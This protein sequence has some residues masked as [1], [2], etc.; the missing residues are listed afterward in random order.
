M[1]NR[2]DSYLDHWRGIFHVLMLADHLPFLFPGLFTVIAGLFEFVGYVS[3]AEGFV[4]LS[5]YVTGLVY[6]R[7][8]DEKGGTAVLRKA[9][10]RALTIYATYVVACVVLVFLAKWM[11]SGNISWGSWDHLLNEPMGLASVQVASLVWQPSFLEI[12]PMYSLF[13]LAAPVVLGQL[14]RG[15][16][17][18]VMGVSVMLWL[19]NMFHF[20]DWVLE[21]IGTPAAQFGSFYSISWQ[22]LFIFGLVCGHRTYRGKGPWLSR[23]LA[24]S[25][26]AYILAVFFFAGRH[27]VPE[28]RIRDWWFDRSL[29]GPLR[30]LDFS[31][32]VFL[33]ARF[34]GMIGRFI[35]WNGFTFLSRH[36]LQVFAFHLI[37]IYLAAFVIEGKGS[38]AWWTQMLFV[39]FSVLGLFWIAWVSNV[40]KNRFRKI[41]SAS[42]VADA[43]I[44]IAATE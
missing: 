9:V 17:W 34:R 29:L 26:L 24:L 22:I 13:L 8:K 30:L 14:D 23:S 20:R 42:P 3:V 33:V 37:P 19:A 11:G 15:R 27:H 21:L 10:A 16:S 28:L 41:P 39:G 18:L 1:V 36:S 38:L 40:V 2:R 12:L 32:I 7:V 25:V 6:T 31:C 44:G 5:G 4:F 43:K 35:N